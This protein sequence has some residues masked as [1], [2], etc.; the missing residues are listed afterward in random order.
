MEQIVVDHEHAVGVDFTGLTVDQFSAQGSTFTDCR[1]DRIKVGSASF[2]AGTEE[3]RYLRCSF[4]RASLTF[5]GGF[6]RFVSCTFRNAQ[7]IR[8]SADYLEFVDCVFTERITG[9]Q[10][11]GAP[12]GAQNRY[13]A[14]VKSFARQGKPEP[15]G[16][17]ELALRASNQIH[18]NDFAGAELISVSFRFGV[19]LAAQKLPAGDDYL[20]LP[21]AETAVQRAVAALEQDS[22]ELAGKAKFFLVDVLQREIDYGQRQLF[23]RPKNFE[24]S[25]VVPPHVLLAVELLR[26]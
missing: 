19:D 14:G 7:F 2:G 26:R 23:I 5:L 16:Y 1:F 13:D 25:K 22:S 21:D 20:Y 12:H 8:P 10:M 3:S 6:A 24:R 4:D 9:L 15:P 17:R 11:R 18:G